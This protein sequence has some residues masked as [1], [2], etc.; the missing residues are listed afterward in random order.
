MRARAS[1]TSA[2]PWFEVAAAAEPAAVGTDPSGA[3]TGLGAAVG[4]ADAATKP[5]GA[6]TGA[7][8]VD[9]RREVTESS[10]HPAETGAFPFGCASARAC[11]LSEPP[12]R[13]RREDT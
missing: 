3:E 9:P 11:S 4:A 5:A 6:D 12:R 8:G 2:R 7:A 13:N 1:E 10:Y